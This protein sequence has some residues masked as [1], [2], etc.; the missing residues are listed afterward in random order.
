M[1]IY[2]SGKTNVPYAYVPP[3]GFAFITPLVSTVI[4]QLYVPVPPLLPIKL[5]FALGLY[6]EGNVPIVFHASDV[7][8]LL[9]KFIVP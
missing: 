1:R 6:P 3:K 4:R 2:A 9:V 8:P 7:I 5:Q